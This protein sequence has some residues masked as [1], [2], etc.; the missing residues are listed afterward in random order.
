[1]KQV[2][3]TQKQC[4]LVIIFD[5]TY[6]V[7]AINFIVKMSCYIEFLI[8]HAFF[9]SNLARLLRLVLVVELMNIQSIKHYFV[10]VTDSPMLL[11][12]NYWVSLFS[13]LLLFILWVV[14]QQVFRFLVLPLHHHQLMREHKQ[15]QSLEE[16]EYHQDHLGEE[17][18]Y[19]QH[20]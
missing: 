4:L 19:L 16:V 9:F 14:K 7:Q 17:V 15:L 8:S 10:F 12:F 18:G 2:K 6:L 11:Q 13:S 20:F 3:T 5:Q 1:M